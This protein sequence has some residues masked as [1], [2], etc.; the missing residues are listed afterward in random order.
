M[1]TRSATAEA[2]TAAEAA[3]SLCK[4]YEGKKKKKKRHIGVPVKM[5]PKQCDWMAGFF[6]QHLAI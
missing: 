4:K 1:A 5:A 3:T 2:R 6:N